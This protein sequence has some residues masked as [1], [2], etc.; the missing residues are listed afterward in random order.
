MLLISLG[1]RFCH[2]TRHFYWGALIRLINRV[3]AF[4]MIA[5]RLTICRVSWT[6]DNR[7]VSFWSVLDVNLLLQ[8]CE[9]TILIAYR[10]RNDYFSL[11]FAHI[12]A[13]DFKF[14]LV[15]IKTQPAIKLTQTYAHIRDKVAIWINEF[16]DLPR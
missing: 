6:F 4:S 15:L 14:L 7:R 5:C 12:G 3:N 1:I 2:I 9:S 16:W 11:K 13:I 10:D 8:F